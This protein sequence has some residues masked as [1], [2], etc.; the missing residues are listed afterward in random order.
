VDSRSRLTASLTYSNV[1]ATVAVFLALGGGAYAAVKL[2]KNSVGSRQLK[3]NAVRSPEVKRNSL[4]GNDVAEAKLGPVP[5][6]LT[7]SRALTSGNADALGGRGADAFASAD[8][9][10]VARAT[11]HWTVAEEVQT[12]PVF[13]KG[14][15]T[16]SLNCTYAAN[17]RA[18]LVV[19]TTAANSSYTSTGS[20][21]VFGPGTPQAMASAT[22]P[23]ATGG[24]LVTAGAP[25]SLYS[26]SDGT[27]LAGHVVVTATDI[28]QE[29]K[30]VV[31]AIVG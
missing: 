9:L 13:S 14:P 28:G 26:T 10:L 16:V 15:F 23:P 7:A 22:V 5:T 12:E 3:S 11:E 8:R 29:C 30:G 24:A 25:F 20:G 2:P 19:T 17:T 31:S 18:T 21:A 4:T 1:M 6:A 27:Y